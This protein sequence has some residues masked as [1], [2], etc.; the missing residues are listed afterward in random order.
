[1]MMTV[2]QCENVMGW[3]N[4]SRKLS[5]SLTDSFSQVEQRFISSQTDVT[6]TIHDQKNKCDILIKL[7]AIA[8]DPGT[9]FL[10]YSFPRG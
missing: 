6:K 10:F 9:L 3:K 5:G 7:T 1:M 8:Q 4:T 2:N